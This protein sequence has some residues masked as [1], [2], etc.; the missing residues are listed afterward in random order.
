MVPDSNAS[1]S[2][3][4]TLMSDA[5]WPLHSTT[6]PVGD[7]QNTAP[8]HKVRHV[9]RICNVLL[10]AANVA[11]GVAAG[12]IPWTFYDFNGYGPTTMFSG[13]VL[14]LILMD[15]RARLAYG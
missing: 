8:N 4:L 9:S 10:C 1:T 5:A 11:I 7:T 3:K 2:G 14:Y 15:L 13:F 6:I 12:G